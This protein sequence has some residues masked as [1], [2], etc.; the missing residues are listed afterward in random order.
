MRSEIKIQTERRAVLAIE[1][2]VEG[3][4]FA[5]FYENRKIDG[6]V[7]S[8]EVSKSED[9]LSEIERIL[10]KNEIEKK[11]IK[12][13]AVSNGP[14][15]FTGIRIGAATAFGLAKALG[16]DIAAK[17]VFEAM[18]SILPRNESTEAST[19]PLEEKEEQRI[20]TV[21]PFGKTQICLQKIVYKR[22]GRLS[23]TQ[24]PRIENRSA[25]FSELFSE[26]GDAD[27]DKIILHETLYLN[28]LNFVKE[29]NEKTIFKKTATIVNAGFNL[30]ELIG[31]RAIFDGEDLSCK[32]IEITPSYVGN[33]R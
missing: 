32:T 2:A 4:S 25:L 16:C 28:I 31:K 13:I 27:F 11:R 14:G 9:V 23:A 7:G 22:G 6:W 29:I 18:T 1:T 17:S 30:A 24:N 21:I 26:T 20:L 19:E 8:R 12:L 15:S 33:L 10:Q 3:G 5:L